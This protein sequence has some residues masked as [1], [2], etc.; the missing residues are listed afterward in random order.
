M[1]GGVIDCEK[2]RRK[3]IGLIY[4]RLK[5]HQYFNDAYSDVDNFKCG[6]KDVSIYC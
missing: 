5:E 4:G 1:E 6:G 3:N 2:W